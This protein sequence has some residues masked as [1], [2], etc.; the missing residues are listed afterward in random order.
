MCYKRKRKLQNSF[1]G[2]YIE[3]FPLRMS[4][5]YRYILD[6]IYRFFLIHFTPNDDNTLQ[7]YKLIHYSVSKPV[8]CKIAKKP[9]ETI[10]YSFLEKMDSKLSMNIYITS[11]QCMISV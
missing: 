9:N 2:K 6:S 5:W 1:G 10:L 3:S 7:K 4:D 11:Q 8:H